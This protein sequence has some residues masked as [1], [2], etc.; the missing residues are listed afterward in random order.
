MRAP[1]FRESR[2]GNALDVRYEV[3][4]GVGGNMHRWR[5][6]VSR[7]ARQPAYPV[8]K[9]AAGCANCP[10]VLAPLQRVR[11]LRCGKS[12]VLVGDQLR[13]IQLIPGA[14]LEAKGAAV[15]AAAQQDDPQPGFG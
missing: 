11:R 5:S 3:M 12:L 14:T 10:L 9:G 2:A 6:F 13:L 4:H 8:R 7:L 15:E 1:A